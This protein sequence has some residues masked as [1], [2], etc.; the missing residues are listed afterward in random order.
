M[1]NPKP[2][3]AAALE[4]FRNHDS[5]IYTIL[6]KTN[7]ENWFEKRSDLQYFESLCRSIIGQ[8]L[9][10]KAAETIW[11]RFQALFLNGPIFPQQ[12]LDT[13]ELTL[14]GV[15][16]SGSKSQYVKNIAEAFQNKQITSELLTSADDETVIEH[17][18]QIKGIGR[19]TAEMF[20][21]FTLARP[22]IFSM[23]DLGL[24]K[25]FALVYEIENP[26]LEQI[27]QQVV[28]WEPYKTYGSIALWE[29]LVQ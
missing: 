2:D 12:V 17:L 22:N 13:D 16:L 15:G 1:Q 20:L 25:G 18:V 11:Q 26:T 10:V 27:K 29:R 21:M 24:K 4:H 19:W 8:Q 14:R 3:H 5:K 9:S 28:R 6:E 7:L 23:G